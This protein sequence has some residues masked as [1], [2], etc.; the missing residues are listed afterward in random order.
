[1]K[2]RTDGYNVSDPTTHPAR[3][4]FLAYRVYDIDEEIELLVFS[5]RNSQAKTTAMGHR[6]FEGIRYRDIRA[7]RAKRYDPYFRAYIIDNDAYLPPWM[8]FYEAV[9]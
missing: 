3:P 1:M 8:P 4:R 5:T 6:W 7:H 9:G 2:G